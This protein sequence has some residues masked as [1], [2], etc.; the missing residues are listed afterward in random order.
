M[1]YLVVAVRN[2]GVV[3]ILLWFP[4]FSDFPFC[5]SAAVVNEDDELPYDVKIQKFLLS[6]CL[7]NPSRVIQKCFT[8]LCIAGLSTFASL[9]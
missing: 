3:F 6:R 5:R 2:R 9:C 4:A 8:A 7:L 1:K